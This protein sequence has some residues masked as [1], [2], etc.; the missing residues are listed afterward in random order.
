MI[1]NFLA[2]FLSSAALFLGVAGY[3]YDTVLRSQQAIVEAGEARTV[4]LQARATGIALNDIVSDLRVLAGQAETRHY[5]Q[6][7]D[8]ALLRDVEVEFLNFA[9]HKKRY[10]QVRILDS[11]G[12]EIVRINSADGHPSV[13]SQDQ[14]QLKANRYYYFTRPELT[15]SSA[16][17]FLCG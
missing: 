1:K 12:M 3:V 5:L 8:L 16:R 11:S 4:A 2:L 15:S 7:R 6:R 13:V 14:L 10:D 17:V 9:L